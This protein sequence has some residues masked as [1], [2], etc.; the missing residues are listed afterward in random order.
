MSPVA[1]ARYPLV[2]A[3][4]VLVVFR[5]PERVLTVDVRFERFEL[6][7][8]RAH[9]REAVVFSS[10]RSRPES[11][12]ESVVRRSTIPER[13]NTV[14]ERER[15]LF[16]RL[17]RLVERVLRFPEREKSEPERVFI[18]FERERMSPVAVAR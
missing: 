15:K 3:R 10:E 9:E 4:L 17:V 13:L 5:F 11:E 12:R 1:V 6:V 8:T 7:V 16:E 2:V 18:V 14:P